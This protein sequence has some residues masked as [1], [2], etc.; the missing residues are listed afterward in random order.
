MN[1]NGVFTFDVSLEPN[2]TKFQIAKS[3]EDSFNGYN[4]RRINR[5][6]KR[7]GI[8]YNNFIIANGNGRQFKEVHK[9][10]IYDVMI[11]FKLADKAGLHIEACY[12]CFTFNDVNPVSERAQFV[13]RKIIQ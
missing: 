1:D 2:S 7:T 6:N 5:Y 12:D 13:M 3:Y 9:Q 8:H 10:K 4:F 11:Y